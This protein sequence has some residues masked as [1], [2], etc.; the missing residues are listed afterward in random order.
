MYIRS[1]NISTSY[2]KPQHA[3]QNYPNSSSLVQNCIILILHL[4]S[5]QIGRHC[6]PTRFIISDRNPIIVEWFQDVRNA[7]KLTN[8]CWQLAISKYRRKDVFFR[9]HSNVRKFWDAKLRKLKLRKNIK[10]WNAI[11]QFCRICRY[12]LYHFNVIHTNL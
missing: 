12:P 9:A 1:V 8:S 4:Y 2:Q 10:F 6:F 7:R 11:H 3:V 5:L